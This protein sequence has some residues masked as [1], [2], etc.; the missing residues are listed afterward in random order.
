MI[1][2]VYKQQKYMYENGMYS[3]S[4]RIVNSSQPYIRPIVRGKAKT[5]TEFGAKPDLTIDNS[6]MVR[7]E[8]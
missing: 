6:G 5:L 1:L 3:V 7:I 8:K 2:K 4:D